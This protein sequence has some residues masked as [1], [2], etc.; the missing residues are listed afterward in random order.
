MLKIHQEEF[1]LKHNEDE[2]LPLKKKILKKRN[3]LSN[4]ILS[5]LKGVLTFEKY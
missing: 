4:E 2:E 1:K 5:V 3:Q